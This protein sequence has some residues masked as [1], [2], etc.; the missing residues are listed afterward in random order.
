MALDEPRDNDET[1]AIDGFTF[2]VDKDFIT[3]VQPIHVDWT[4]LG[5]KL[6][7]AVQFGAG[8]CSGCGSTGTCG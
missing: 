7:C 1:F 6:D 2:L 5:F 3:K 4:G 8:G